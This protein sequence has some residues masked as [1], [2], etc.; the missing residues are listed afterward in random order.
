MVGGALWSLLIAT[1]IAA[2]VECVE[3]L[4]VVLA[5]GLTRGWRS[6]LTGVAAGVATIAAFTAILGYTLESY[7]SPTVLQLVV[8]PLLL[9]LGFQWLRKAVLRRAGLKALHDEDARFAAQTE[10]ALQAGEQRRFGLDWY[11]FV[12]SFKIVVLEGLEVA[13]I[14]ITFGLSAKNVP[15]AAAAAL[16]AGVVMAFVGTLLSKPLSRVPEN[17]LKYGVGLLLCTYGTFW[18]VEGLGLLRDG[19]SLEWTGGFLAVLVLFASWFVLSRIM[20]ALL[21]RFAP[22]HPMPRPVSSGK[23]I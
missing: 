2:V 1:F 22:H 21:P 17:T 4:S 3:T 12:V 7:L 9:V 18:S 14:I 13:A 19:E 11:G 20:V 10:A 15:A 6:A 23:E 5:V 8:G 16:A